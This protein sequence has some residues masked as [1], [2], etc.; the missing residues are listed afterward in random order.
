MH[1]INHDIHFPP[2]PI[3]LFLHHYFVDQSSPEAD[4]QMRICRK[5]GPEKYPQ[6][7]MAVEQTVGLERR[8]GQARLRYYAKF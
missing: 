8:G 6:E 3:C 7:K 4:P 2:L 1:K 5:V